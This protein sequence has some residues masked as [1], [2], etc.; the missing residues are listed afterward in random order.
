MHRTISSHV[1]NNQATPQTKL[2]QNNQE[3]NKGKPYTSYKTASKKVVMNPYEYKNDNM[4]K[5]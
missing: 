5:I 2:Y 1:R 3:I 4:K